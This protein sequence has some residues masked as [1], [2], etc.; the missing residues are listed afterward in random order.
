MR[1]N[2][3]LNLVVLVNEVGDPLLDT[4]SIRINGDGRGSR[5]ESR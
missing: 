5:L 3:G 2:E 4:R 1:T